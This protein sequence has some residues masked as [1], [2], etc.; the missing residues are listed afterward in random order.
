MAR[1]S[2][3]ADLDQTSAL[4]FVDTTQNSDLLKSCTLALLTSGCAQPCVDGI[5]SLAG[6]IA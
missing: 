4:R 2:L 3:A 5:S 1:L 6:A